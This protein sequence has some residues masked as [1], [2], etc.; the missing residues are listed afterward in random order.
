MDELGRAVAGGPAVDESG[1]HEGIEAL[2]RAG[3]QRPARAGQM[4]TLRGQGVALWN[5]KSFNSRKTSVSSAAGTGRGRS[6]SHRCPGTVWGGYGGRVYTTSMNAL[7]LE[8]YYRH[9]PLHGHGQ[10]LA[11]PIFNSPARIIHVGWVEVAQDH[12]GPTQ[13]GG[14]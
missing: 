2:G 11:N 8:V 12:G 5:L 4:E 7:C 9:L 14:T 3:D 1:Q 10:P 6:A 13:A